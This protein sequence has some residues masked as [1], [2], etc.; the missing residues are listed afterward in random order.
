MGVVNKCVIYT[1]VHICCHT[2]NNP[3]KGTDKSTTLD[4]SCVKNM[5]SG[6]LP[7][8]EVLE[9]HELELN[10]DHEAKRFCPGQC[11]REALELLGAF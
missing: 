7:G 4:M 11:H 10:E 3:K 6:L 9:K 1:A 5:S 8:V 2:D